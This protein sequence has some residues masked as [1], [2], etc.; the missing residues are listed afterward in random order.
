MKHRLDIQVYIFKYS[1]NSWLNTGNL[2][3]K[4]NCTVNIY[5]AVR[6]EFH[7]S[8]NNLTNQGSI[9][10]AMQVR[11]FYATTIWSKVSQTKPFAVKTEWSQISVIQGFRVNFVKCQKELLSATQCWQLEKGRLNMLTTGCSPVKQEKNPSS[12][13]LHQG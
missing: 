11:C 12:C 13:F 8:F 4:P 5:Q 10:H 3:F 9:K 7:T 2:A 6:P 1:I